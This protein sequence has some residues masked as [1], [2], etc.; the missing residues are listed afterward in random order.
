MSLPLSARAQESGAVAKKKAYKAI[1]Q[2]DSND[3][4]TIEKAEVKLFGRILDD[5]DLIEKAIAAAPS[6]DQLTEFRKMQGFAKVHA[7]IDY[8]LEAWEEN[9]KKLLFRPL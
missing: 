4:K 6:F 9:E 2:L 5:P 7:V 8:A 3:P 1:Y